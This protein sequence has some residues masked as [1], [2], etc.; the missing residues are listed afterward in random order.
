MT[1]SPQ[2]PRA[3][4]PAHPAQDDDYELSAAEHEALRELSLCG[5]LGTQ[6]PVEV[7]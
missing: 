6:E 1:P 7:R 4:P 2:A 3:E 5:A